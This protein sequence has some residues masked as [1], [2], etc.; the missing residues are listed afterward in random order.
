MEQKTFDIAFKSI[1]DIKRFVEIT[2]DS[3]GEFDLVSGRYILDGKSLM[4][5]LSIPHDAKIRLIAKDAET[6]TI[7]KLTKFCKDVE[8]TT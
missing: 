3:S 8:Q 1:D 4:G 6:S 2:T 5:L 7:E